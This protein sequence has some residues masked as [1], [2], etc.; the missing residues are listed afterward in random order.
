M[1]TYLDRSRELRATADPHYN[2][3][4]GVCVPFAQRAGMTDEQVYAMAQGFGRGMG[5]GNVCGA[6]VGGVMALGMLGLADRST[7]ADLVRRMTASHGGVITCA[8]LLRRCA[9]AG[10]DRHEHCDNMVFEAV[11]LVEEYLQRAEEA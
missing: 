5:T 2:C 11:S 3:A 9:E 6:C 1:G 8:Q 10:E 4:Q 7:T